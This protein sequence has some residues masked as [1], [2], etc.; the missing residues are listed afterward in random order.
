MT[1]NIFKLLLGLLLICGT[2]SAQ[3]KNSTPLFKAMQD[4]L[5]R[6]M[7]TLSLPDMER[8]FFIEYVVTEGKGYS[9]RA[10]L[11]SI[12]N[13]SDEPFSR[14]CAVRVLV[15]SY[16]RTNVMNFERTLY[17]F[18]QSS[19]TVDDNWA[20][21]KRDFWR[22]T[23]M[24]YKS[25]AQEYS[26]KMALLK[27]KNISPEEAGLDDFAKVKPVAKI[28]APNTVVS[29]NVKMSR[30]VEELSAI[31]KD[32]PEI[33]KSD[34]SIRF[35]SN[36]V[37]VVNS[38]NSKY[39]F[40]NNLL[41]FEV[42]ARALIDG[43][44]I[45]DKMNLTVLEDKDLPSKDELKAKVKEFADRFVNIEKAKPI[46]ET[47]SG[48]VLFEGL[49]VSTLFYLEL[50]TGSGVFATREPVQGT[51]PI[52]L[53]EKMN[54][55]VIATEYTIKSLPYLE[56]FE[57]K[58]VTG[59]FDIDIE[60]IVPDKELVLVENGILKNVFGSRMQTKYNKAPNGY[61]RVLSNANSLP[62]MIN[63]GVLDI[64]TS[65]GMTKDSLKQLLFKK[66]KEN[67]Y[68]YAYICRKLD[69]SQLSLTANS[70]PLLYLY[71][72]N[73]EDGSEELVR[74]AEVR[75]FRR[76]FMKTILGTSNNKM[77]CNLYYTFMPVT[78]ICPDAVLL[79]EL[80][81]GLKKD[82]QKTLAPVVQNPLKEK[83]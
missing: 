3:E 81:I 36:D 51:G 74:D 8:P 75:D 56:Q 72:V 33:D 32:Y 64:S 76:G 27:Q 73:L 69:D 59:Y 5:E 44:N 31:F 23:D 16:H 28:S 4:E 35:G 17:N 9:V 67:G 83:F 61:F 2:A 48:P 7:K 78:Y 18:G 58:K 49:T 53:Q 24:S 29:D 55:K 6:N 60:G 79:P 10:S 25:A 82:G 42:T 54:T 22:L 70:Y 30:L 21:L 41:M 47:Y 52:T 66:V 11:G 37:F 14:R 45:S 62:A 13:F 20:Q 15:G 19:T 12:I 80:E 39:S 26:R 63:P 71:R 77:V 40:P 50:F 1:K 38:E 65:R 43:K 46:Q 68:K 57:G 34:V